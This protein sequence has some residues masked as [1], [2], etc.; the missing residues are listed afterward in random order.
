MEE[1]IFEKIQR[2]VRDLVLENVE[3]PNPDP[4]FDIHVQSFS[5]L[6]GNWKAI[7]KTSLADGNI[8]EVLHEL[9][10]GNTYITTYHCT[11]STKLEG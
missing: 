1:D 10:Y 2:I 4:N 5:N 3:L 11:S 7:V 6:F 9:D 8:Y